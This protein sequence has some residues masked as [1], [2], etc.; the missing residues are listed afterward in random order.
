MNIIG[1]NQEEKEKKTK[2]IMTGIIIAIITLL[3]ISIALYFAIYYLQQQQ[4]KFSVDGKNM[5]VTT[6]DLFIFE[7]NTA[8][9]SLKDIAP[10]IDY[11]Y[12]NGGYKQYSE[13]NN[14]CYLEGENEV[15][16]FEK[17]SNKIYKTPLE[18]LDY[19]FFTLEEP[20][21][22]INDKLYISLEG[23]GIA[24][25]LQ[26]SY[27]KSQNKIVINTLPYLSNYYTKSYKYSAVFDNF[28]NQKALLY[29]LLIVQ[30][31][32]NSEQQDY[33]NKNIRYGIYTIDGTE[34]VGT[35]YTNI[36]FIEST[37]EFI[38]T[39]EENKV[40]I[41]TAEGETKVKP[42]YDALKQID[43]DL[44]LY[45][46]TNNNK[47]GV[48][49]KNGKILIYLEYDEVGID[50]TKFQ[51]NNIKNSYI[52]FNNAIPV[53]QNDKW[54]MY[55]VKGKLI[56]SL[57]YDQIGCLANN[58]NFN[59][60]VVIPDIEAIVFGKKYEMEQGRETKLYG[61]INSTGKEL[62]PP[63]LDT[64]Y[65]ITNNGRDEY[66]MIYDKTSYDVIDYINKY[67]NKE[68]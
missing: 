22:M 9:V 46:A 45:L 8:Y 27:D 28:N 24:C 50:T 23:I 66:T 36:E 3:I 30:N 18:Q 20:I 38:V 10:I 59:N 57:Q 54:G 68:N 11:K 15:C 1:T 6:S 7:G 44:N 48:I 43:K 49:E 32:E 65:S 67:G 47:K 55:D 14:S 19:Q 25:N 51:N 16:T 13:D 5:Q 41:I 56:V 62:V 12:Y 58:K 40:G 34:I 61:I 2:K 53:K 26:V 42:Q 60:I 52:L 37:K 64:V 33:I 39:T 35:K 21:K 17:D 31:I 4:F 63:A 29:N